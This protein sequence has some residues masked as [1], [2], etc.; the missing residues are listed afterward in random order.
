MSRH[1]TDK[2]VYVTDR[3]NVKSIRIHQ[4]ANHSGGHSSPGGNTRVAMAIPS[5]A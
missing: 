1:R 3:E 5:P 2:E 4:Q